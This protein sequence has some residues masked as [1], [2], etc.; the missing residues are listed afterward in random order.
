V[1]KVDFATPTVCS[2]MLRI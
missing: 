1:G 2:T